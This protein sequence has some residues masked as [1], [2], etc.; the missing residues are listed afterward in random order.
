MEFQPQAWHWVV[1]GVALMMLELIL[2]SF[3]ALWFGVAAAIIALLLWIFPGL[4]IE[5][6]IIGWILL[7]IAF[8]VFWFKYLKPLSYD[9]TKA[10]LAREA[11]IGQI[12]TVIAAPG[13]EHTGKI[14]FPMPILGS[15][16]WLCRSQEQLM[17]GDRVSV[18]D[19]LGNE[20]VVRK[21]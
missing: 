3:T 16:E 11:I 13:L 5:L 1:V 14:R 19:I 2:P 4:P 8:T 7:S 15:D 17:V 18:M 20:V 21:L 10:G 9:K 6:Q 12:G